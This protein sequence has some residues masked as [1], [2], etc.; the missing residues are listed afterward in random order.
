MLRSRWIERHE[1]G[2]HHARGRT[3]RAPRRTGRGPVR[4]RSV[5]RTPYRLALPRR[6]GSPIGLASPDR[7]CTRRRPRL[8]LAA[9]ALGVARGRRRGCGPR[10]CA[11]GGTRASRRARTCRTLVNPAATMDGGARHDPR[12]ARARRRGPRARA[13]PRP[14]CGRRRGCGPRGRGPRG[15]RAS[16]RARTWGIGFRFVF[17]PPI[18]GLEAVRDCVGRKRRRRLY[19]PEHA[20]DR[21]RA[22]RDRAGERGSG[23]H[24]ARRGVDGCLHSAVYYV[25]WNFSYGIGSRTCG[26][27][28]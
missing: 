25:H 4:R 8:T 13:R 20:G 10:G 23:E 22:D 14:R 7:P 21:D 3:R 17:A 2:R 27:M 11:R 19:E 6:A 9:W 15:T 24:P 5:A 26:M 12:R 18:R 28:N 1:R 16:R